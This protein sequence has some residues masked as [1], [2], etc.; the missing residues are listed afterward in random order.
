VVLVDFLALHV[1]A[2][3]NMDRGVMGRLQELVQACS[4]EAHKLDPETETGDFTNPELYTRHQ[5]AAYCVLVLTGRLQVVA[6]DDGF[7]SE[8][9][10]YKTLAAEALTVMDGEEYVP[11]FS[12][13]VLEDTRLIRIMRSQYQ[14][15]VLGRPITDFKDRGAGAAARAGDDAAANSPRVRAAGAAASSLPLSPP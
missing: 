3:R 6:T 9:G 7:V 14:E 13:T 8:A 2:F 4:I 12:T 11:D 5:P 10:P 1:G 15:L